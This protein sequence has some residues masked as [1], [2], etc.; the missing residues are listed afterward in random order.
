MSEISPS[1]R[2]NVLSLDL[3]LPVLCVLKNSFNSAE[4]YVWRI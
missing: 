1:V 4:E 3:T 2:E